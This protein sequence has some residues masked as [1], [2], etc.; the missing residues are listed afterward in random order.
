MALAAVTTNDEDNEE[1]D[2]DLPISQ[3]N[4]WSATAPAA[5]AAPAAALAARVVP[6]GGECTTNVGATTSA[7]IGGAMP[8]TEATELRLQPMAAPL[9][10]LQS[11]N[12]S[13]CPTT[14]PQREA[15]MQ[16]TAS[17]P[18]Q[19]DFRQ[20]Y[21]VELPNGQ[22]AEYYIEYYDGF[23]YDSKSERCYEYEGLLN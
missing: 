23:F 18:K 16:P 20:L 3:W 7:Q 22:Y 15:E 5:A 14:L 9:E 12:D 2:D 10:A 8:A 6:S 11:A 13:S 1:D 19:T 4:A 21:H 17:D